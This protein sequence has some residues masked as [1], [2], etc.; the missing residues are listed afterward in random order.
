MNLKNKSQLSFTMFL[1]K[2]GSLDPYG[3]DMEKRLIIDHKQLEF[4]KNEG[5]TLI[6]IPDKP[7]GPLSDT[8]YFSIH[9]Y[10]FDIIQST[11]QDRNITWKF[12]KNKPK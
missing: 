8:E 11:N 3:E 1:A 9:D 6:G 7:H 10:L 2:Y 4:D 12:I 5:W